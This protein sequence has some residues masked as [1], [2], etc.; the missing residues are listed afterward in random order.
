MNTLLNWVR[1]H[2][3]RLHGVRPS[4]PRP[5]L[6]TRL[7]LENLEGRIVPS[8]AAATTSATTAAVY[9]P[10]NEVGNNIADPTLGTAG[11]DLLRVSAAA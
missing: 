2:A 3:A 7:A 10:I 8:T 1:R 4:I 11:T 6:R 9:R 5:P